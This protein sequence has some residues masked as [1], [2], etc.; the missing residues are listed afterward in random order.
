MRLIVILSGIIGCQ[1][2]FKP[3][4]KDEFIA[5][6]GWISNGYTGIHPKAFWIP[7][8]GCLGEN[9]TGYCPIFAASND[10]TGNPYGLIGDWDM[11]KVTNLVQTFFGQ[12]EFDTDISKWDVSSVTDMQTVFYGCKAFNQDLSAWDMSQVTITTYMF[13]GAD[14]FN[15]DVSKW[16]VHAMTRSYGMF[17]YTKSF[18]SD[19]SEWDVSSVTDLGGM[20]SSAEAFNSDISNWDISKTTTIRQILKGATAFKG[21]LSRWNIDNVIDM[22][23]WATVEPYTTSI[24]QCSMSPIDSNIPNVQQPFKGCEICPTEDC[25]NSMVCKRSTDNIIVNPHSGV[26]SF[27]CNCDAGSYKNVDWATAPDVPFNPDLSPCIICPVG[28]YQDNV[29]QFSCKDCPV[30]KYSIDPGSTLETECL[31]ATQ[32]RNKFVETRDPALVPAYNIAN[33]CV[34]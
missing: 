28:T 33:S 34:E 13:S 27:K 12:S 11:S 24:S 15:A 2:V 7:D 3:N 6:L 32:I 8:G 16:D 4:N 23:K 19:I 5:A 17:G 26:P 22:Y 25:G 21:D 18:N 29:G 1:A 20:F 30:G 31:T 9:A 10:V 14:K